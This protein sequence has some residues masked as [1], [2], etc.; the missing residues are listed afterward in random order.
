MS[1]YAI[2]VLFIL[3][4][5]NVECIYVTARDDYR[6]EKEL[7]VEVPRYFGAGHRFVR[8]IVVADGLD[9]DQAEQG[10]K[11]QLAVYERCGKQLLNVKDMPSEFVA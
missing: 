9:K 4:L 6:S 10:R 8:K 1:N 5:D 11:D 7:A 2:E 3:D